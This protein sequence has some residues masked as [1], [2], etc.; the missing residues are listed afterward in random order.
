M[1]ATLI[2]NIGKARLNGYGAD[3][4]ENKDG[5]ASIRF[6]RN[7]HPLPHKTNISFD[8]LELAE[9]FIN[10]NEGINGVSTL[11]NILMKADIGF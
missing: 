11:N 4:Y 3:L 7:T 1:A 9:K 8:S 2:R 5:S 6:D 10:E